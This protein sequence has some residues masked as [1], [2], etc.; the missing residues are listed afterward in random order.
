MGCN[1][2][3]GES[4]YFGAN[5]S[6]G[7]WHRCSPRNKLVPLLAACSAPQLREVHGF[8]SR[9]A[10]A[11]LSSTALQRPGAGLFLHGCYDH[12]DHRDTFGAH[13]VNGVSLQEALRRW[14]RADDATPPAAHTHVMC[15]PALLPGAT[16]NK[17]RAA[18]QCTAWDSRAR[19]GRCSKS[20][21]APS[22]NA[23]K[24]K[25]LAIEALE[26]EIGSALAPSTQASRR[27]G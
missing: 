10:A 22:R 24:D 2:G 20:T 14:W 12:S 26:A 13:S 7:A 23:V 5:C 25:R 11:L 16:A 3:A 21:A 19:H 1:L 8:A 15:L 18:E 6:A 9:T 17:T 4:A 27:R